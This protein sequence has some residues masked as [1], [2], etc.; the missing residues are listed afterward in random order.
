MNELPMNIARSVRRYD[1]ITTDGLTLYPVI[2]REYEQFIVA[3]PALEVMHQSLPVALL[4]EPLL[5]ALYRMDFDALVRQQE[6]TGLFSRALLALAL[7]LRLGEGE[8]VEDR[9]KRFEIDTDRRRPEILLKIRFASGGGTQEIQPA[10]Y[11]KLRRIIAAQNGV[12]VE[13]DTANP[14]IVKAKKAAMQSGVSLNYS[15]EDL[16]SSVAAL[17]GTEERDIDKWPILK[18]Q[19]RSETYKRILDYLICGFGEV[20]GTTWKSGNPVP[21]P[22]FARDVSGAEPSLLSQRGAAYQD[23]A[24]A[25]RLITNPFQ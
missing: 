24:Q 7:S 12:T 4:R 23:A 19:K 3:R 14:E 10:Q 2:V 17:S 5:A 21:H 18:L 9:L 8:T 20:N 6:P 22:Y 13:S 16:V 1:P 11:N 15:M 25:E